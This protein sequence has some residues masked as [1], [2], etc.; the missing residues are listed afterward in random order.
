MRC[1]EC[2][3]EIPQGARFCPHCGTSTTEMANRPQ[4][5][6]PTQ[7]T[8]SQPTTSKRP[9]KVPSGEPVLT[10]HNKSTGVTFKMI[11]V[12]G[13]TFYMGLSPKKAQE[14]M[15]RGVDW[16]QLYPLLTLNTYYIGETV[17]TQGLWKTIMCQSTVTQAY[18]QS[19]MG[20]MN[21]PSK[22]KGDNLP[23]ENVNWN[24]CQEFIQKL[25]KSL[26]FEFRLPTDAEW[27]FAARGGNMSR[28]YEHAG[29]NSFDEVGWYGSTTKE[30]KTKLPNELGIYDMSGNVLEWCQDGYCFDSNEALLDYVLFD[31]F[32]YGSGNQL[33]C[34]KF[35]D[36][37]M[38]HALPST[39]ENEQYHIIRGFYNPQR[40]NVLYRE[41]LH[42]NMRQS[43]C[44]NMSMTVGIRLALSLK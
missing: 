11:K 12:E 2:K 28:G 40:Y 29:S 7:V 15:N 27:E 32:R 25:N 4:P 39:L 16:R 37:V 36:F 10:F 17:V 43:V 35:G 19:S 23:V 38:R 24:N 3:S 33:D 31:S 42:N 41:V 18:W 14:M 5:N 9:Y 20:D 34:Y 13:G 6:T 22:F 21:N 26:G 1:I 44:N 8:G 30:V